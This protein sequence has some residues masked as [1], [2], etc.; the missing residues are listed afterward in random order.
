M[1]LATRLLFESDSPPP[2]DRET[3]SSVIEMC[4]SGVLFLTPD[5]YYRQKDGVAMGSPLGPQLA[6]I[7]MSQYDNRLAEGTAFYRRYID[8][9]LVVGNDPA[10][11]LKAAN[12]LKATNLIFTMEE[13]II[14][15][16]K[17]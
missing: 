5:G 1:K 4:T 12:G 8:D 16:L 2:V 7:F 15:Q 13:E 17:H 3:F 9:C 14:N 11:K 10:A 6:N